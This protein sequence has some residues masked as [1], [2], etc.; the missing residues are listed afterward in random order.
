MRRLTVAA[1]LLAAAAAAGCGMRIDAGGDGRDGA[2]VEDD[3]L[4]VPS[5]VP[6]GSLD[7][8]YRSVINR[9]CAGQPGLCHAGQFEPNLSTS[10]LFYANLVSRPGLEHDRQLRVAPGKPEQSLLVDKLRN[11][12]VGTQM[13]LGAK[14]LAEADI[15]AIEQWIRDGALRRPGAPPAPVLNN[16]PL[17]PE[18]AV[19]DE[20]GQRI[21]KLG[22]APIAAGQTLML[23]H[24]VKDF[25]TPDDQIAYAGFSAFAGDGRQV[26]LRPGMPNPDFGQS[27]YDPAGAP[28]FQYRFTWVVPAMLRLRNAA[29]IVS[30]VPAKGMTLSVVASYV[31]LPGSDGVLAFAIRPGL[32]KVQ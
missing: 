30:E 31:D 4:V 1:C 9:S 11:R 6:P 8:L 26:E 12:G 5:S 22:Q 16:P 13:P 23:R 14:P 27:I 28:T 18:L 7:A 17:P 21:D 10:A 19:F 2:A 25:E 15:A 32:L 3:P 24:S 29:G 20:A